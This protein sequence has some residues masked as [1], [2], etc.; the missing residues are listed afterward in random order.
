MIIVDIDDKLLDQETAMGLYHGQKI[1]LKSYYDN[2]KEFK[3]ILYHEMFHA[4]CEELGCQ[5]DIHM[6][7]TLA[8]RVSSMFAEY[9]DD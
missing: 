8:H 7:E 6:E 4:L 3:R 9:E 5:L 1:T 2:K